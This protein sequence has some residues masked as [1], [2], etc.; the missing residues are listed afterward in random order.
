MARRPLPRVLRSG[1]TTL[2]RSRERARAT[3]LGASDVLRPLVT[4][5]RGLY[6]LAEAGRRGWAGT[7]RDRRGPVLFLAGS[8]VLIVAL[9]PFGPLLALAAVTGAAVWYGRGG[10]RASRP[11]PDDEAQGRRLSILYEALVPYFWHPEDPDPLY[12]HGGT[13]ERAFPFREFDEDGD[14]SRVVMCY[15]ASF[16]DGEVEARACVERLVHAKSGRGHEYHFLWDVEVNELTVTVLPPLPTGVA[17]QRFRTAPGETL[18]GFTDSTAVPWTLR[19]MDGAWE[20]DRPPVVWHADGAGAEPHLLAAGVPGCGTTTLLRSLALQAL[21]DGD[22]LV[23]DGGGAGEYAFLAGRAGVLGVECGLSSALAALE[24]VGHETRR[25]LIAL[26][27]ARQAGLQPPADAVRPLWVLLDRPVPLSDIAAAD[28]RPDPQ[29]LLQVPLRYGRTAQVTVVVGER[30]DALDT[31][32][33]LLWQ[34]ARARVV[35][36]PAPVDVVEDALGAPPGTTPA[37]HVPPGRGYARLGTGPVLRLQVPSTPDPYDGGV[38][39]VHRQAVLDLLP[40]RVMHG[41]A[42]KR[43]PGSGAVAG[44]LGAVASEHRT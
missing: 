38:D 4:F 18:L 35:L 22:V 16:T 21:R 36:G 3:A 5:A 10:P 12:T 29:S 26:N 30:T 34:Y 28:G 40:Q 33:P 27:D 7:P 42:T 25:R 1:R 15:P 32:A 6:R 31:L 8:A 37:H 44:G 9:A 39:A 19:V 20:Y 24:W 14:L 23:V 17:A 11:E 13:W 41:A 43:L 2:F